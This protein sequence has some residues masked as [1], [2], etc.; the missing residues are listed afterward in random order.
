M[1]SLLCL[2]RHAS[3]FYRTKEP[4]PSCDKYNSVRRRRD[5]NSGL[6]CTLRDLTETLMRRKEH[7]EKQRSTDYYVFCGSLRMLSLR[8]GATSLSFIFYTC[9]TWCKSKFQEEHLVFFLCP[10]IAASTT[11]QY[12]KYDLQQP[13]SMAAKIA[14]NGFDCKLCTK[15]CSLALTG[16]CEPFSV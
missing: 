4:E 1:N 2:S 5:Y 11:A 12:C 9:N 6:S 14:L 15:A 3:F 8:Y 10:H 7:C 16:T 13:V